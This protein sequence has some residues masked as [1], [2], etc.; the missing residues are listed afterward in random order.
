[1]WRK[2]DEIIDAA[3]GRWY[4]AQVGCECVCLGGGGNVKKKFC[5]LGHIDEVVFSGACDIIKDCLERDGLFHVSKTIRHLSS[6]P[7]A[8]SR[9]PAPLHARHAT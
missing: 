7:F 1:M 6:M 5:L 8:P 4:T 2:L 3:F 9:R